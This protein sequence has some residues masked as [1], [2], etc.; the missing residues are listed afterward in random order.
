MPNNSYQTNKSKAIKLILVTNQ[1][2]KERTLH[3]VSQKDNILLSL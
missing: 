1:K 2:K 3:F